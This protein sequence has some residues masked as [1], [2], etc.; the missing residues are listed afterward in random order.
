MRFFDV[1]L[2][3]ADT[4]TLHKLLLS[5]AALGIVL[6][7]RY[8][9]VGA[10]RVATGAHP[11]ERFVFWTR[12]AISLATAV[13][14]TVTLLSIWFSSSAQ[15]GTFAGFMGAGLAFALQKVVTAFAGYLVILR[16]NTF[17]VGDRITMGGVRGDVISL[18]FLQTRIMEMGEPASAQTDSNP[19]W[20]RARQYTG[21][22][23]SV[24]NDKVFEEPIY[25][26]TREFPFIW[27]EL[28]IPITYQADRAR[29]EKILLEC[30]E[31][32]T[33]DITRVS[34][35]V[36]KEMERKYFIDINTLT[37]RVFQSLT[38]NWLE[39]SLR[40]ISRPHGA[41][42]VKDDI[43]RAVLRRFDAE[44]IGIASATYD[45]VGFPPLKLEGTMLERLVTALERRAPQLPR[46]DR[47][48][49]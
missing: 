11:N 20:V 31:E 1:V 49:A 2:L 18:G 43:S 8:G 25:N 45:V 33:R 40:F 9:V 22:V 41:R 23:V 10:I 27:E 4:N 21:R 3:G 14:L 34:E 7:V 32:A 17:T 42:D 39:L 36:R 46:E 37:P 29:A 38:D 30:A 16:G 44:G 26:Y 47:R 12:Q 13:A 28:R 6:V 15:L 35:D 24:T 5:V 48:S 19:S